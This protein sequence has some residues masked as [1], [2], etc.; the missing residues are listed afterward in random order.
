MIAT[1]R[2]PST[3]GR[4]VDLAYTR[5]PGL[6]TRR[7]PAMERSRLGPYLRLMVSV[8]P[9]SASSTVQ[10]AMYPSASRIS[11]MWLLSFE[12]GMETASL[13]AELALRTRVNMSAI[14][15]VMVIGLLRP[16]SPRFPPSS[17]R[18]TCDVDGLIRGMP[19]GRGGVG[20]SGRVPAGIPGG[21]PAGLGHAG[22]LAAVGHLPQ[23]DPAQAELAVD[24]VG[25][26]AALAARVATHRELRLLVR[27]VD[28]GGLG[29]CSVL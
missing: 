16:L 24:R 10:P 18:R 8:L 1:P 27:L 28:E 7:T 5:R 22:E 6:D 21:S 3:F 20:T 29:H 15:S 19:R 14:G 23:A 9:T 11:A 13:C 12:N 2:P 26:A 17:T 4:L 25:T